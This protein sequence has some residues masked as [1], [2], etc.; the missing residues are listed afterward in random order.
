M[1][2][3]IIDI[4]CQRLE[5]NLERL[6]VE[7]NE[8]KKHVGVRHV[9]VDNLLPQD[10][11][12][13]IHAAFPPCNAMRLMN[14]FRERKFTSK[15]FD[16]FDPLLADI[17]F[18]VQDPRVISIVEKITGI[19]E[20]IP[21]ANLYAGGLSA[22]AQGHFLGPH[23][24]NSHDGSREYYR[25]L[26]LLYYVSPHWTL[27]DG[28]NLQLWDSAVN[29]HVT[30]VSQFN[31]LV[32]METNPWSW[33]SVSKVNSNRLRCCVSNY[34]FSKRS[35]IGRD[36]SNITAFSAWPDQK[37]LRAASLIDRYVRQGVR[38]LRPSGFGKKDLYEGPPR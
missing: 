38:Y 35:P 37:L 17:T 23:L 34:Y 21:D 1:K 9:F 22:M 29:D 18:A 25:T 15:K 7:F 14:N 5:S 31:R 6:K 10:L 32:I 3:K 20:Q 24:D 13:R 4:I 27:E 8:S 16:A 11:A 19:V 28:G 26:N 36:Y 33:H 12:E 2:E 30:I